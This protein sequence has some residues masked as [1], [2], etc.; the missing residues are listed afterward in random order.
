MEAPLQVL[1]AA[2]NRLGSR[3]VSSDP[4]RLLAE[5]SLLFRSR[6]PIVRERGPAVQR[7]RAL[8]SFASLIIIR[9]GSPVVGKS[10]SSRTRPIRS[11]FDSQNR[12]PTRNVA[13]D[14]DGRTTDKKEW[15]A[16]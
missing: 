8:A 10:E 16:F 14:C 2:S 5:S 1:W 9:S 13:I 12:W 3:R 11:S 6:C 7:H 4:K 15:Y